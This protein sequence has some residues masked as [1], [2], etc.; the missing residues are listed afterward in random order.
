MQYFMWYALRHVEQDEEC[1]VLDNY[2]SSGKRQFCEEL[3]ELGLLHWELVYPDCCDSNT[4]KFPLIYIRL[5]LI[6]CLKWFVIIDYMLYI[7]NA[8]VHQTN[9]CNSFAFLYV[10]VKQKTLFNYKYDNL[11]CCDLRNLIDIFAQCLKIV[12]L[13]D[14]CFTATKVSKC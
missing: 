12:L 3:V 11:L 1:E 10:D 2:E 5:N 6:I 8:T 13:R 4:T 9:A 7:F 14:L